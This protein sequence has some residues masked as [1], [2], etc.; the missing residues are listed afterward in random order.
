MIGE[1]GGVVLRD[2][3]LTGWEHM[4]FHSTI[5]GGW[6][7]ILILACT[8]SAQVQTAT[9]PRP[10]KVRSITA[11][12]TIDR[13]QYRQQMQ[14]ALRMLNSAKSMFEKAGYE[15]QTLR[16]TTQP[17]PQYTR[18]IS[19]IEAL[20]FF[21]G[22]DEFGQQQNVMVNIGPAMLANS[23]DPAE[24]ELLGEILSSTGLFASLMV[25]GDD[26][27]HWNAV[28]EA[29]KVIKYIESHSPDGKNNFDFAATAV[30]PPYA[31]FYPGSY[32]T[33]E[34]HQFSIAL[35][36]GNFVTDVF[37]ASAGDIQIAQ[38]RL[39]EQLNEQARAIEAVAHTVEQQSGWA[40]IGIDPTPAPNGD[41]S[42]G[43]AFEK[44][45]GAKFGSSGTLSVAAAI[46]AAV[47]G[48]E[49][50]HAGYSG[51]MLPP[52]EDA[53][54]AQRWA[55]GAY[56]V[57]SL[58]SY[59]AVCGTGLDTVPLP[60]DVS[61]EQLAKMIA[62]V[63]SL[64]FKWRKPLTARLIPVPGKKAGEDTGHFG[65]PGMPATTLQSVP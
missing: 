36:G 10:V 46:T 19:K 50:K 23:D 49:A 41:S 56:N 53:V 51:L 4:K 64:A 6:F 62:D 17:F 47:R 43:A 16:L 55:E 30:M 2:R 7:A 58:L 8:C 32:H 22:L 21:K 39:A 57:D 1:S 27:I 24:A 9:K 3:T 44:L 61:E 5:F 26:G 42:I 37:A 33:G 20:N 48:V 38:K 52:L 54:L 60:G 18:G 11:F 35:E 31:P 25:A 45:N 63:A 12:I 13:A 28:H 14:D 40:Y 15:V 59:S 34:G 29:A 65:P